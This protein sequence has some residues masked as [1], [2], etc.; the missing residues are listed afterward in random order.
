M[1]NHTEGD[2]PRWMHEPFE[3][4]KL[5]EELTQGRFAA[6]EATIQ[7][8]I[9]LRAE[10]NLQDDL[11]LYAIFGHIQASCLRGTGANHE[12]FQI[13]EESFAILSAGEEYGHL[14]RCMN[15]LSLCHRDLND[16]SSAFEILSRALSIAEQHGISREIGLSHLNL[17]FL[18]SSHDREDKAISHFKE[19][20][21]YELDSRQR[22]LVL[23]NIA[24]TL[25]DSGKHHEAAGYVVQGLSIAS[26]QEAPYVFAHLLSNRAMVEAAEGM[27]E[28]AH[29]TALRAVEIFRASGH[30]STMADPFIDLAIMHAK[31]GE[32]KEALSELDSAYELSLS[33]SGHP[34]LKR[35]CKLQAESYEALGDY[36]SACEALNLHHKLSQEDTAREI[37]RSVKSAQMLHQMEWAKKEAELLRALNQELTEA[38]DAAEDANR[39]K[40]EFL[41]NM[42]HE[43]RTPMNGVIG[44]TD[45]LLTTELSEHQLEYVASIKTSGNSLLTIIN[46]ILDFSKMESGKF[47]IDKVEF[48][49]QELMDST[50]E[51]LSPNCIERNLEF[52]SIIPAEA[53]DIHLGDPDRIRQV[54]I[55]L[56]GNA[57]KFTPQGQVVVEAMLVGGPERSWRFEITDTGVGIPESMIHSVF[58][59][60]VQADGSTRRKFGG[61]GLGLTISKRLTELMGGRI[62]VQSKEGVGSTFWIELPLE[63][64][65][66]NKA[67]PHLP[68]GK[69]AL[70]VDRNVVARRSLA[71]AL[72]QYGLQSETA[73]SP[74]LAESTYFDILFLDESFR[75]CDL[76]VSA[77]D[78]EVPV[79]YLSP[80]THD[81]DGQVL[82][83]PVRRSQ[84]LQHLRVAWGS[85]LGR[86]VQPQVQPFRHLSGVQILV[87]EDNAVNRKV[88][89]ALLTRLGAA[90]DFANDGAQALCLTEATRY[91]VI[92]MDCQMPVM[93]GFEATRHLRRRKGGASLPI[94]AMTANA[95]KG[96]REECLAAGMDD[97]ISKPISSGELLGAVQRVLNRKAA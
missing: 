22:P 3:R 8:C 89:G 7:R 36:K 25:N 86:K 95:M 33:V 29:Q 76:A 74:D 28:I 40:S 48:C 13:A 5:I 70:V 67:K 46:D 53:A 19:A 73:A 45:R 55:N 59:S 1:A 35:I 75:H 21:N 91:D 61:T 83:K 52:N 56:I 39:L 37:D 49:I 69:K 18:Y 62:G 78:R 44:M 79:L 87:V 92:L 10:A 14:V 82:S 81:G 93:D 54:L 11:Q 58:E 31:A 34:S 20:L 77:Q 50:V 26:E 27:T 12:A 2:A 94:V 17:G 24:G 71:S 63:F 43:I 47:V 41:A 23:N 80:N 84:L 68:K 60:F 66:P 57:I 64:S 85:E 32:Y 90:V 30:V 51:L 65:R 88:A 9:E 16:S 72:S 42:S 38:K 97:Y 96:D 15:V 6:P 4:E